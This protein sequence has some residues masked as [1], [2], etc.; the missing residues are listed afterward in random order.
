[1]G[2]DFKMKF[3]TLIVALLSI[4]SIFAAQGQPLATSYCMGNN[5]GAVTCSSCFNWGAGTIGPKVSDAN[6]L[7][8]TAYT[9]TITHCKYY[10]GSQVN[11][12]TSIKTNDCSMCNGQTWYNVTDNA[13]NASIIRQC[14]DTALDATT[15]AAKVANCWQSLCFKSTGNVYTK[16]CSQCEKGYKGGATAITDSD[17]LTLGFTD[18]VASTITNVDLMHGGSNTLALT[19]YKDYAVANNNAS[20]IA[21]TTDTG[22]RALGTGNAYCGQCWMGYYF[23][24]TVCTLASSLIAFAGILAAMLTIV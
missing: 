3:I 19:C 9:N 7:C 2:I 23:T 8:T 24:S 6:T 15:C 1:M 22:C 11:T 12:T 18:C 14:A 4:S 20:C 5:D 16:G 17:G 21:F 10:S 13:T